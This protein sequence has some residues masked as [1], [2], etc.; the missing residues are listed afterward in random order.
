MGTVQ[1]AWMGI[2]TVSVER[3]ESGA[4]NPPREGCIQ[5]EKMNGLS[6]ISEVWREGTV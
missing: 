3:H 5:E 2:L 1:R 6:K 4:Q